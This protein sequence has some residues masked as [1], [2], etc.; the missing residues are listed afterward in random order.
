MAANRHT[1]I[2]L[3]PAN[4]TLVKKRTSSSGSRRRSS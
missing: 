3:A 1:A 4:G 2:A